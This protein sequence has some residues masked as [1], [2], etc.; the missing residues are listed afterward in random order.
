M[1]VS[2][3][4]TSDGSGGAHVAS[5]IVEVGLGFPGMSHYTT[6]SVLFTAGNDCLTHETTFMLARAAVTQVTAE[7][8][9]KTWPRIF[10]NRLK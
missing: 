10:P 4:P 1:R 5:R 6:D 2:H 9:A 7:N 3:V 8:R